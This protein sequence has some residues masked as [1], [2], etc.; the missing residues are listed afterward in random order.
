VISKWYWLA[1]LLIPG[2]SLIVIGLELY[3]QRTSVR[4]WL[5]QAYCGVRFGHE[6]ELRFE[7]DRLTLR[8]VSCGHEST[9][10]GLDAPPPRVR[11]KKLI[12]FRKRLAA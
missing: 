9:G 11:F 8:C 7:R 1:A 5:H 3:R 6:D 12:R 2:G 10:W 4:I